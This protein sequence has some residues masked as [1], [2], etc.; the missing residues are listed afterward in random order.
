MN[1]PSPFDV[2]NDDAPD[3]STVPTT[4]VVCEP[5]NTESGE[6]KEEIL[7]WQHA[8]KSLVGSAATVIDLSSVMQAPVERDITEES[9][10][11]IPIEQEMQTNPKGMTFAS[12]E[13]IYPDVLQ[14]QGTSVPV[15]PVHKTIR[16]SISG[17]DTSEWPTPS[18]IVTDTA[19]DLESLDAKKEAIV[20]EISTIV[21]KEKAF[22][23]KD[24]STTEADHSPTIL[25]RAIEVLQSQVEEFPELVHL[26]EIFKS[27]EGTLLGELAA[28]R[29]SHP[30]LFAIF[31][32]ELM[33]PISG[34][35]SLAMRAQISMED[36]RYSSEDAIVEH[37]TQ[38]VLP[39]LK[40]NASFYNLEKAREDVKKIIELAVKETE[41][42][43]MASGVET[44]VMAPS[45]KPNGGYSWTTNVKEDE[46]TVPE[47]TP[48][49]E[50]AAAE[51]SIVRTVSDNVHDVPDTTEG[52]D[53]NTDAVWG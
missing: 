28:Y 49:D 9:S 36:F 44:A 19:V 22:V 47:E 32:H 24:F 48:S 4:E 15:D 38:V 41:E 51:T 25:E 35:S 5:K 13:E 6:K 43:F 20:T 10:M 2:I 8:I 1:T 23:K 50:V 7:A 29:A 17:A 40:T 52:D 33:L 31:L 27:Q 11:V 16:N 30:E 3:E 21:E 53:K 12:P 18:A 39:F 26:V 14:N 46:S 37:F 34:G 42:A 45:D